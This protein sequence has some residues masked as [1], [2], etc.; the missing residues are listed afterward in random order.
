[1]RRTADI[2]SKRKRSEIMSGIRGGL[3][4]NKLELALHNFLKGNRIRHVMY[5]EVGGNPDVFI[6]PR[7]VVFV[8]GC[9]WHGCRKHFRLPKTNGNFWKKK[10]DRNIANQR[11]AIRFLRGEGFKVDIVWEHSIRS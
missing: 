3:K 9:F 11:R 1:M 2:F 4:N 10:I 5:P 8:N 7:T 6:F